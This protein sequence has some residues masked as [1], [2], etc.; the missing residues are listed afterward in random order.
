VPPKVLILYY[1][2]LPFVVLPLGVIAGS[3]LTEFFYLVSLGGELRLIQHIH[4]LRLGSGRIISVRTW[5]AS[6]SWEVRSADGA[7]F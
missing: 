6:M 5:L 7:I 2:Y 4:W 1:K 3:G